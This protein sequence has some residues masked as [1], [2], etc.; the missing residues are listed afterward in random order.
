MKSYFLSCGEAETAK[1]KSIIERLQ[2]PLTK[3]ILL[4]LSY[5]LPSMDRFNRLF[6]KSTENHTCQL[7]AEMSRLVRLYASNVLQPE[8]II[9]A[10]DNLSVLSQASAD[11]LPNENLGLGDDTWVFIASLEEEHDIAPSYR[12]VRSFYIA[13]ITKMLKKFPFGDILKDLG[14]INPY[15]V[16][17]YSFNTIKSLA[18]CFKQVNLADT[19]S[20]DKLREEFMDFTL[21][22]GDLPDPLLAG[23]F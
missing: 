11:Q 4:L 7:Y 18:K 5:I 1:V 13:T 23:V 12:A 14:I 8:A 20:L 9:A 10:G 22:P 16:S 19:E 15:Q 2:H 17:A 6:Q 3:P 21:S